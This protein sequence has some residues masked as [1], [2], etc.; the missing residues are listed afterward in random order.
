MDD[1]KKKASLSQL[2]ADLAGDKEMMNK[3]IN[4]EAPELVC[5]I[6]ELSQSQKEVESLSASLVLVK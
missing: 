1:S 2:V 5:M 3:A 6:S 4:D